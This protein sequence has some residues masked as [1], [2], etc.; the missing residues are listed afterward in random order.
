MDVTGDE[1]AGVVDLFDALT[2]SELHRALSELAYKRGEDVDDDAVAADVEAALSTY[3]LVAVPAAADSA[4]L[5]VAGPTAF[6]TLPDS[7]EDLPHIMDVPDRSL[8]D[9]R[10]ADAAMERFERDA[11][12]AVAA[13]DT[14][15]IETLLD[16][17]YELEVWHDLDLAEVRERLAD[18][19]S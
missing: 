8:D 4:E 11:V 16:V 13:D 5:L 10:V 17:S 3:H 19:A 6:P 18:A 14:A 7:A 15:R 1:L 2:R 12:D 9:G